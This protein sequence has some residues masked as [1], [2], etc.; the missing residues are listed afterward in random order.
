[1]L[2]DA[3]SDSS[4]SN[5]ELMKFVLGSITDHESEKDKGVRN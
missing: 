2:E 5:M 1:M 3:P 4:I